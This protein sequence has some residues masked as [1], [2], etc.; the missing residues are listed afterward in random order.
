MAK[1]MGG[2]DIVLNPKEENV[3][4]TLRDLTHGR[5]VDVSIEAVGKEETF[6]AAL[7]TVKTGGILSNL[8][9]HGFEG[10]YNFPLKAFMGGVGDKKIV[11]TGAPGGNDRM[12]RL[13]LLME[14]QGLDFSPLITHTVSLEEIERG[15]EIF[16][17]QKDNAI[18][19]A[20]K[21]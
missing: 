13:L 14:H 5:M 12:R 4:E 10:S 1:K 6:I 17:K 9:N 2:V 8:G 21:P 3:E 18:K 19:V 15:Y 11:S 16:G 7:S 20:V